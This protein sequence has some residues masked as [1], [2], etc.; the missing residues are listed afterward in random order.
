MVEPTAAYI[1]MESTAEAVRQ[2]RK[3]RNNS[4]IQEDPKVMCYYLRAERN[5]RVLC[6]NKPIINLFSR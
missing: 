3:F 4:E 1:H 2:L 5:L 6:R